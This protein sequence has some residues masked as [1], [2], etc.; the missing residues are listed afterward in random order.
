MWN[1]QII[2][3]TAIDSLKYVTNVMRIILQPFFC[4]ETNNACITIKVQLTREFYANP[5]LCQSVSVTVLVACACL[6]YSHDLQSDS[7]H[8]TQLEHKPSQQPT[9]KNMTTIYLFHH[10]LK[11]NSSEWMVLMKQCSRASPSIS[12]R[13]AVNHDGFYSTNTITVLLFFA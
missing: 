3:Q 2:C 5:W 4:N 6:T 13:W 9:L 10:E 11:K 8:P 12:C 7:S 1:I